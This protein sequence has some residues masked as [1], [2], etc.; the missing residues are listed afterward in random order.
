MSRRARQP[1]TEWRISGSKENSNPILKILYP[2]QDFSQS[3]LD[4]LDNRQKSF[5]PTLNLIK[6]NRRQDEK[7]I[8]VDNPQ[9]NLPT[10]YNPKVTLP[11]RTHLTSKN[12]DISKHTDAR[13][14]RRRAM[15]HDRTTKDASAAQKQ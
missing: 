7:T 5:E 15:R 14:R 10:L 12:F 11:T 4:K 1:L 13:Q 9:C 2:Q 6:Q 8:L 3:C